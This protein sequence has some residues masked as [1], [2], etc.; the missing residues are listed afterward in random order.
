MKISKFNLKGRAFALPLLLVGLGFSGCQNEAGNKPPP[1]H[2]YLLDSLDALTIPELRMR[3]Y[4]SQ[5][6]VEAFDTDNCM[7]DAEL[8]SLPEETGTYKSYMASFKS[9]G[10]RQYGRLTIPDGEPPQN[11]FP[12]VL[13]LHGYVGKDKAPNYS[14]G[15]NPDNLYYSELTDALAR[16]GFAVMAPGY[17]GHATVDGVAAEGLEY[18][19]AFDQGAGLSTQFYAIDSL[20]FSA[21]LSQIDG[22]KFPDQSFKLDTEQFFLLAH[23]Q[24][25]DA[26]LSYLAAIGEGRNDHLKPSHSALWS[27]T[28]LPRLQALEMMMPV[29]L[30]PEAFLSGD[31]EWNGTALGQNGEVNPNFV[32]GY[33]PDWIED[34]N[35]SHWTWQKDVWTETNVH[36]AIK[37][38]TQKMYDDLSV[39]VAGL[40]DLAFEMRPEINNSWR[41]VHDD[42]IAEIFQHIGGYNFHKFLQEPVTF[43]VPEKDYYSQVKWN[44]NLCERMNEEGASPICDV[45]IYPHNN[46]SMRASK[47]L[48]FSPEGTSDG[49]P[50]FLDNV[51]SEF[52]NYKVDEKE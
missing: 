41:V 28:F 33:P 17:R 4:T 7:G 18:L 24:G 8:K 45:I 15:C 3:D 16:A 35:P 37:K 1:E 39:Y 20:N 19:V 46:H 25:G 42:R 38:V 27:G 47:H 50:I 11:G 26:A 6:T 34:P 13:F 23:S 52:S 48:W 21:G 30:T 10:I 36:S 9:D 2:V 44:E 32:F 12:Y 5:I 43:H 40:S 14:I 22:A 29:A 31:G 51:V 49:Y